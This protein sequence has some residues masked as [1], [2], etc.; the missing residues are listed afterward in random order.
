MD[1]VGDRRQQRRDFLRLSTAALGAVALPWLVPR[2]STA[3][4]GVPLKAGE[5]VVDI[6]PPLGIELAGFHR[7]IDMPRVVKAIRQPS[8]VRAI[9]LELGDTRAAIVSMDMMAVS[10]DFSRRVQAAVER[11]TGIPAANVRVM[12]TH[13]HSM[14]TL[15][16][17][18]QWGKISPE[19]MQKVEAD[20]VR[21]VQIAKDDLAPS[22]LSLGKARTE[23][24]GYNRTQDTWKTEDQFDAASTDADRWLDTLL[25]AL[26]FR[27]AGGNRDLLWYHFSAHPVCF[28]DDEAG[29]DWPGMVATLTQ[30]SHKLAPSFLQGNAGDVN[31]GIAKGFAI[32][33]AEPTAAAIYKALV[34]AIDGAQ[35][36]GVDS[37]RVLAGNVDLPYD[38]HRFDDQLALYRRDPAA[39]SNGEW[40]DAGFAEDWFAAAQQW[41][42]SV[43]SLRAP[44]SAMQLG[45][46]GMVFHPSELYSYY[47]LAI[48]R[49]SP[50]EHTLSIGY[51]DDF[52]G[53][54]PDPEAF[55][56]GEYAAL[57]VP[58]LVGVCPYSSEAARIL[59]RQGESLLNQLRGK[60]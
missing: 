3:A 41:D 39:C 2:T 49:T 15:R 13:T 53:Y 14:P 43:T 28:T 26:V 38:M 46:I 60:A 25:H 40:V 29:P 42:K 6:T 34:A 22:E 4:G 44:L 32:A 27:R 11:E 1:P 37:L 18:R 36:V 8:T 31:P 33:K 17:V 30:E 7:P 16:F 51:T 55:V 10:A 12:A 54:M 47:G 50:F 9:V 48:K 19:Y 59:T 52:V 58:K 57:V 45:P 23:G 5:G 24:G 56:R 35:P 20:T 21:A